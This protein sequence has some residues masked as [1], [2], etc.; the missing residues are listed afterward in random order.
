MWVKIHR[1]RT[2]EAGGFQ[3]YKSMTLYRSTAVKVFVVAFETLSVSPTICS[4]GLDCTEG[5]RNTN[6]LTEIIIS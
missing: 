2:T 1:L 4:L 3:L 5:A 6:M